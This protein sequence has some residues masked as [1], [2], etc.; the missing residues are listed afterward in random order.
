MDNFSSKIVSVTN[1]KGGVGK[2]TIST[3]IAVAGV[4]NGYNVVFYDLDKQKTA[5]FYFSTIDEKYRPAEI[6]HSIDIKP[7]GRA[8]LIVLDCPPN[9]DFVPP[10]GCLLVSPTLTSMQDLHAFRK[11][12]ELE[13]QGYK[14]IKV[15]NQFNM[16]RNDDKALL[17]QLGE[18]AVIT[19]NSGIRFAMSNRKSIWN[20]NHPGG[21]K[22]KREFNYLLSR[23]KAGSAESM[24]IAKVK[25]ISA[26]VYSPE[27][28]EKKDPIQIELL[29]NEGVNNV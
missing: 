6:Y 29:N 16:I 23:I 13:Q 28:E 12:L 11:V 1:P 18:C 3:Q 25:Q 20:S 4:M 5:S 2:T 17:S 10:K 26:G 21:K 8:D 19:A 7:K 24:T 14:V 9:L 27:D 15:I 22:A